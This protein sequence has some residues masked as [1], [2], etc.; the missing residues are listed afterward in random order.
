MGVGI[1]FISIGS[2]GDTRALLGV[3][4]VFLALGIGTL[5]RGRNGTPR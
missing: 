3:G 1:A 5:S 4:L 2:S